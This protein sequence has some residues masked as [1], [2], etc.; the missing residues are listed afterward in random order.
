MIYIFQELTTTAP[1]EA[2]T[3][4]SRTRRSLPSSVRGNLTRL[5]RNVEKM[6]EDEK[7]AWAVHSQLNANPNRSCKPS[8]GV[9]ML[10]HNIKSVTRTRVSPNKKRPLSRRKS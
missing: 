1:L 10:L 8:Y 5:P 4:R 3:R 9:D 7:L 2:R 6:S